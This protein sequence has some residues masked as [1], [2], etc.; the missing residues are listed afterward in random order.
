M[1]RIK[2]T[3]LFSFFG[4]MLLCGTLFSQIASGNLF[5]EY[6]FEGEKL[7]HDAR[8]TLIEDI[9]KKNN[10]NEKVVEAKI[11]YP[12]DQSVFPPE[13][14]AP[15]FIW[16][17]SPAKADTWLLTFD[18]EGGTPG[19]SLLSASQ[20][21]TPDPALWEMI[22]IQTTEKKVMVKLLGLI[23]AE[24]YKIVS[25]AEMTFSTSKDRV[26][27][28]IFFRDVPLPF[29]FA[30][31][32][33]DLIKW[34]L[35]DIAASTPPRVVLQNMSVCGNCHSFSADGKKMGMDVDYANDKGA[36]VIASVG[37]EIVF[38]KEKVISWTDYKREENGH[39]YGLLGRLSPDGRYAVSTL[40]D[41]SIFLPVDDLCISQIFFPFKGI[42]V[43]YD[44][45]TKTFKT[46]PGA[47][48]KAYVQSSPNWS[49]DGKTVVFSKAKVNDDLFRNFRGRPNVVL[50]KSDILAAINRGEGLKYDLYK[51]PFNDGDG[52]TPEPV[53]GAGQNGKSNFFPKY[54]P[55]GKWIV[56]TQAENYMLLQA[57]SELFILPASGGTAKKMKCNR[58]RMNSWHSWSPNSRWLVF[59]SKENTPYTQLFLTHIDE[60][61]NDSPPVL[62][63]NFTDPERAANIPEFVNIP[64]GGIK[65]ISEQCIDEYSHFRMGGDFFNSRLYDKAEKEALKS[66]EKNPH[67]VVAGCLLGM[68]FE[69]RQEL[70]RS[71]KAYE[72][73]SEWEP[74]N[75]IPF[76]HL[77]VLHE[78]QKDF[79]KA[80]EYYEKAF[81]LCQNPQLVGLPYAQFLG[82]LYQR[83]FSR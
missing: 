82:Y 83:I 16:E 8:K 67:Y 74:K 45:V 20:T 4:V 72:T 50:T 6:G 13:I 33:M 36:Y 35:G 47:D 25:K 57:D 7:S 75:P 9:L 58:S 43:V 76:A 24:G 15:K 64:A 39:T 59:S 21:W 5:L 31:N 73:A 51:V 19:I 28:P 68:I 38:S 62:L 69:G 12:Y 11:A 70:D 53:Q 71:E 44:T 17:D 37:E 30:Y 27:A 23:K 46:L 60:N 65:K 78:K 14:I 54:S 81:S 79:V 52:G 40:K 2:W 77:A 34:R 56:F 55:D 32:N 29:I 48:D 66:L 41:L 22:K 18:F 42:L 1:N 26:D 80:R 61:G 63:A 3:V 49:P 10:A